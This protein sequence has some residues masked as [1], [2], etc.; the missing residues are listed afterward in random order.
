M[1]KTELT[2]VLGK[3]LN[4]YL[5]EEHGNKVSQFSVKGLAVSLEQELI[6]LIKDQDD[7]AKAKGD[8]GLGDKVME[9]EK[10]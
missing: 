1:T 2:D 10:I 5:T 4:Q 3:V 8:I 9:C 6:K 7:T